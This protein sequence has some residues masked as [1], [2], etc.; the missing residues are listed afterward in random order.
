MEVKEINK[1]SVWM[2]VILFL[3]SLGGSLYYA[4]GKFEVF[5]VCL[6][7]TGFMINNMQVQILAMR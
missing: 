6:V 5:I 2:M 3:I 7:I 1:I 4:Q